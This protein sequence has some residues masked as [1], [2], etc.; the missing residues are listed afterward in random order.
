MK[1]VVWQSRLRRLNEMDLNLLGLVFALH[2]VEVIERDSEDNDAAV[3]GALSSAAG[4]AC[5]RPLSRRRPL[6]WRPD[7]PP[8]W[9]RAG[10]PAAGRCAQSSR[11]DAL[12]FCCRVC[13]SL[14]SVAF[15][16]NSIRMSQLALVVT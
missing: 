10:H 2:L 9:P 16:Q 15:I 11:R 14:F 12:I 8:P 3:R 6:T 1:A 4:G 7:L 13:C 5:R